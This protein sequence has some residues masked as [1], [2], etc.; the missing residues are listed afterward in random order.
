M[1]EKGIEMQGE[2]TMP[3]VDEVVVLP[4]GEGVIEP[5]D[6]YTEKEV[7]YEV[8]DTQAEIEDWH[9]VCGDER[10]ALEPQPVRP[11]M[12]GGNTGTGFAAAAYADWS[13]FTQEQRDAGITTM[14]D[15]VVDHQV[16]AG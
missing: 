2:F 7:V 10:H 4:V 16:S 12:F 6:L 13:F 1:F 14:Y 15:A 9:V 11:K 3:H 8:K 5:T